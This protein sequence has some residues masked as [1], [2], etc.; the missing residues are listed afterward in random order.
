MLVSPPKQSVEYPVGRATAESSSAPG[1][2]GVGM[3]VEAAIRSAGVAQEVG[4]AVVGAVH[5]GDAVAW[6][7]QADPV[8]AHS[9]MA[10][11]MAMVVG[12]GA[13]ACVVVDDGAAAVG[14]VVEVDDAGEVDEAGAAVVGVESAR[15]AGEDDGADDRDAAALVLRVR[16]IATF[17]SSIICSMKV[18]CADSASSLSST[19]AIRVARVGGERAESNGSGGDEPFSGT[20]CHV[21]GLPAYTHGGK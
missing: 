13:A 19:V 8:T 7:Q 3:I 6:S 9:S 12:V 17:A 5:A 15:G 18:I 16:H 21:P 11:S 14:V 10:P 2:L 1:G 20:K 4:A